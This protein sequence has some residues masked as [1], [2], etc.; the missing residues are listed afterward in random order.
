MIAFT[1][2]LSERTAELKQQFPSISFI[3][4]T[5]S[6]GLGKYESR[7]LEGIW[8]AAPYLHNG[9]VP[10]LDDLL[11]PASQRPATFNVGV[12]FD[13]NK[14]GLASDQPMEAGYQFNTTIVGNSNAGHEYGT[15]LTTQER[16][17]LLEYMKTL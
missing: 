17:A 6:P 11:K 13:K 12:K 7:V 1:L 16:T 5:N 14:I 3:Q 2:Y 10:T 9:S 8:A 4:A 15:Q